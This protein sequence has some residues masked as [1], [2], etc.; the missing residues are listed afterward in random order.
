MARSVPSTFRSWSRRGG[1]GHL[2]SAILLTMAVQGA[3]AQTNSVGSKQANPRYVSLKADQVMLRQGPGAEYPAAWVF[4][5]TGLPVQ[6]IEESELWRKVRDAGGTEGWVHSSL[7]SGRRTALVL[8]WEANASAKTASAI[9][10]EDDRDG[11]RPIA[12]VEPGVLASIITCL[13]G[14]CRVSVG[15]FR[16]Y[17]EQNKLWGTYPNEEIKP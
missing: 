5:R 14:W 9:L 4:R 12:Q 3:E 16:G 10:R 1:R 15:N 8:P 6:I 7:L 11:A 13:K 2:V 17:I